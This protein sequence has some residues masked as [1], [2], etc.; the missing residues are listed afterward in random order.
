MFAQ[1]ANTKERADTKIRTAKGEPANA[2]TRI[3]TKASR[4]FAERL[5]V[6]F[7]RQSLNKT[8]VP[9]LNPL[10]SDQGQSPWN[11]MDG[12]MIRIEVYN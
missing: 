9:P 8:L 1:R 7:K 6:K 12:G 11:P 4:A 10:L 2:Y 3:V 5:N